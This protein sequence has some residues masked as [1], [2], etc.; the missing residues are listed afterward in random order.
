MLSILKFEC[1]PYA[2]ARIKFLIQCISLWF[3]TSK[4]HHNKNYTFVKK[5][6]IFCFF[7]A[8]VPK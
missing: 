2:G 5:E 8:N 4:K 7:P 6:G 3:R 1:H